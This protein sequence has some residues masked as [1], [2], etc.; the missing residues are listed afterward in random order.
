M[1]L[2]DVSLIEYWT[3]NVLIHSSYISKG[4]Y[5]HPQYTLLKIP[6]IIKSC[7]NNKEYKEKHTLKEIFKILFT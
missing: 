7:L 3:E 1:D 5:Y 2:H 4:Q 6:I